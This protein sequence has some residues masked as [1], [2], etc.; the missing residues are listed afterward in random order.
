MF[1]Q[2]APSVSEADANPRDAV[3]ADATTLG[4]PK[5]TSLTNLRQRAAQATLPQRG[6]ALDLKPSEP[7]RPRRALCAERTA[8]GSAA[9]YR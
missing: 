6:A 5:P 3:T 7:D 8:E 2:S 9:Q 4:M 1:A